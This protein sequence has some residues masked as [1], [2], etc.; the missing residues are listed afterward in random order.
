MPDSSTF[1][2]LPLL[3]YFYVFPGSVSLVLM[4]RTGRLMLSFLLFL[5]LSLLPQVHLLA[6]IPSRGIS[7]TCS[8]CC[9]ILW[10][11]YRFHQVLYV[12]LPGERR[13]RKYSL[14]V[15][16]F[17]CA[18]CCIP[19]FST[20]PGKVAAGGSKFGCKYPGVKFALILG[21]PSLL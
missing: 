2:R 1:Q 6:T 9:L 17:V 11:P 3:L 19:L 15:N 16:V 14:I 5:H 4:N 20:K 8:G 18:L 12:P 21:H 13:L 10:A 7:T